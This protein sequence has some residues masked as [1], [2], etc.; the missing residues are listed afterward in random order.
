MAK[1][2]AAQALDIAKA[3][4]PS[5]IV[6]KILER[7][8]EAAEAGRY[9][10][11]VRDFGFGSGAWYSGDGTA[12]GRAVIEEL[13]KLGFK[14]SIGSECLQFVDIWLSVSWEA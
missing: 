10:I 9:Y 6:D 5:A 13:R 11:H 3:K 7:I 12:E 8:K 4:D 2:T 1:L 14:T